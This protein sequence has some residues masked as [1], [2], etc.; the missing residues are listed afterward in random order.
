MRATGIMRMAPSNQSNLLLDPLKNETPFLDIDGF[1]T[2]PTIQNR[3]N[4]YVYVIEERKS[5]PESLAPVIIAPRVIL[6]YSNPVESRPL[7]L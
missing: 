4:K 3:T 7:R 1:L 2:D 5:E 6:A